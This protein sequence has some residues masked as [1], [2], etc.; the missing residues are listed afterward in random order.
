MA[1]EARAKGRGTVTS[2]SS[3]FPAEEAR[4][5]SQ[6]VQETISEKRKELGALDNFIT[7]NTN[8]INLVQR[9][10]DDLHH[11]IMVPF[12]KAAFF[13]GR[14]VHT[15]E[16]MVLLGEGYYAERTAKQTVDIL[17]RRG[18]TLESQVDSLKAVI[19]DLKTEASFFD[20]TAA[21]AACSVTEFRLRSPVVLYLSTASSASIQN[22]CNTSSAVSSVQKSD[23]PST[24]EEDSR[25]RAVDD[26]EY[27]RIMSR[28]DELEREELEAGD[29][30]NMEDNRN[31]DGE[32]DNDNEN[33]DADEAEDYENVDAEESEV[34]EDGD[35]GELK[36]EE[37]D[38]SSDNLI[39]LP[40]LR[41]LSSLSRNRDESSRGK[42]LMQMEASK[43]SEEDYVLPSILKTGVQS[44]P[45]SKKVGVAEH[46]TAYHS[47]TLTARNNDDEGTG[48]RMEH[49]S[50]SRILEDIGVAHLLNNIPSSNAF[51][52][53]I[54]ER[55]DN[56]LLNPGKQAASQVCTPYLC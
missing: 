16:F 36:D 50:R 55:M 13:P 35:T 15:N 3:M 29:T 30:E 40:K 38:E 39:I 31:V 52:G 44:S 51:S 47:L 20:R 8:L 21:E 24:S 1:T 23:A 34:D 6:R 54:V 41:N 27:A 46:L 12:G 9:V 25:A 14:L 49:E 19:E 48:S 2:L 7:D 37:H 32:E 43:P 10:P 17:K 56:L 18:K 22:F 53:T 5:A 11:R 28:F 26:E 4:K 33:R 42:T 45:I